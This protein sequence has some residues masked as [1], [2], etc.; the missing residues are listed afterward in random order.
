MD[1]VLDYLDNL[2]VDYSILPN[3]VVVVDRSA[4][5]NSLCRIAA[6]NNLSCAHSS[7]GN[8]IVSGSQTDVGFPI[9]SGFDSFT[10]TGED[11][12]NT[13]FDAVDRWSGPL[14]LLRASDRGANIPYT[15]VDSLGY[16]G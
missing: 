15:R 4:P 2:D 9:V 11:D 3:G 14:A 13:A 1:E 12:Y 10:P 7:E 8:W 16:G 6:L 5:G